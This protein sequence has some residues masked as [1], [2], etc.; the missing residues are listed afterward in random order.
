M[1]RANKKECRSFADP[2]LK[3]N[4]DNGLLY[5]ER[6]HYIVRTDIRNI[7]GQRFLLLFVYPREWLA[8]GNFRPRWTTFQSRTDYV[9]L[10][11]RE[12]GTT[13]WQTSVFENLEREWGFEKRCVFYSHSDEQRIL[14]FCQNKQD[15]GFG[16]L[17]CLQE[18]L[19]AQKELV[20]RHAKQ[21]RI[22]ERMAS[23]PALP[24]DLKGWIHRAILPQ[25]L[26]YDYHR[27][28]TPMHGYCTACR[29]EVEVTDARH[30]QKGVC[31]R[32][33]KEVLFKSRGR[34]GRIRNRATV[35]VLQKLNSGDLL[36]RILKVYCSYQKQNVPEKDT[37]EV[38]RIF[39]RQDEDGWSF[40]PYHSSYNSGDLTPWKTGY[41]PI[42]YIFQENF[43]ADTCG[44]LYCGN[45]DE[46]LSG[47]P[48][49]Y[50]QLKQFYLRDK[51]PMELVPYFKAFLDCPKLELLFKLSFYR[52]TGDL[53]YR[54]NAASLLDCSSKKPYEILKVWPEDVELLRKK[55]TSSADLRIYQK[56]RKEGIASK[57]RNKI[58]QWMKL[59][60]LREDDMILSLLRHT[61]FHK[62]SRYAEK[63]FELLCTR[64]TDR[65]G[66]RYESIDRILFEYRDYLRMCADQKYDLGNSFVLFPRDLQR[67]HDRISQRIKARLD[68]ERRKKFMEV[69]HRIASHLDFEKDGLKIIYPQVPEDI[70]AEG[71]ALHHCVGS[72]VS[73]MAEKQTMILFLRHAEAPKKSFFTIEV[74]DGKVAQ[75][76]GMQNCGPTSEVESFMAAWEAKV[77][78][79]AKLPAAA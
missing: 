63:Q 43:S 57:L 66:R 10:S 52:L 4:R 31:P 2:G 55:D 3:F 14:R 64:T 62:L 47:T 74:C 78:H 18:K 39:M 33:H 6:L 35:Q 41:C 9:T 29:H 34:V 19:R 44:H 1:R 25:Y 17:S 23:L 32:C 22:V 21:R 61:T 77:L 53:V 56:Y 42:R 36:I 54:E 70:E 28:K 8:A 12:N 26:F 27:G 40:E 73:R 45:L 75:V 65:G 59:H 71:N 5:L 11:F 16:A 69:Y 49:Q 72:Y 50:S 38:T 79:S 30:N 7:G 46:V 58:L 67:S 51:Q 15:S 48:W 68:A 24:R 76:R 20:R 37:F 13:A 60:Q